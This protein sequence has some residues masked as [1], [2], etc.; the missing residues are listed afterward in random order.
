TQIV[1]GGRHLLGLINDVL[2]ISRIETGNLALSVEPV[3]TVQL[4][5]EVLTLMRPLADAQQIQLIAVPLADVDARHALAD[6]QRLKQVLLNLVSN[7]IKYNHPAGS[8]TI[9]VEPAHP[10][11]VRLVVADT[12]PGIPPEDL[13]RLFVAF[14]RLGAERSDIEGTGVG[15]ALSR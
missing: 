9:T 12:G 6:Y 8:V 13:Q 14:E 3:S 15:L 2:D 5:D 10:D 4:V 7:A 1:K 11:R